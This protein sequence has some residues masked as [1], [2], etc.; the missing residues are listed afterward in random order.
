M[1]LRKWILVSG[2]IAAAAGIS[3]NEAGSSKENPDSTT[4]TTTETKSQKT[5]VVPEA[6]RTSFEAKYPQASDVT[7]NY[8]EPVI[9]TPIEWEWTDWPAIDTND[10]VANFK[11]N[12]DD[13]WVWYDYNGDWIGTVSEINDY[14][15]LPPAVADVVKTQFAGYKITS[16]DKEND[17][18]RTAYEI[19]ME[20]GEDKMKALIAEDGT[21]IKKKGKVDGEKVKEKNKD[22]LK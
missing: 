1:Q 19:K 16:I 20:N 4:T 22:D 14:S 21:V 5:V 11:V 17:K 2:V 15:S 8:H 10:Y 18:N 7:W 13:Y 9:T 12:D 3:C 6:T